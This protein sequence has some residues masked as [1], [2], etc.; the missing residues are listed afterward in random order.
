[1]KRKQH[2]VQSSSPVQK[3]FVVHKGAFPC[4]L[5]ITNPWLNGSPVDSKLQNGSHHVNPVTQR[6]AARR[7]RVHSDNVENITQTNN[8]TS[9]IFLLNTLRRMTSETHAT[10][11]SCAYISSA[12]SFACFLSGSGRAAVQV[13]IEQSRRRA[14]HLQ[15]Y[16]VRIPKKER[17]KV[18]V[19][20]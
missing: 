18:G 15:L 5:D 6:N 14:L 9:A 13:R 4:D 11:R 20:K 12:S 2:T 16:P 10:A 3:V 17:G 1:M 7:S 8:C 19:D